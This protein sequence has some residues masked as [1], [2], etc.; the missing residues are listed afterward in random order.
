MNDMLIHVSVILEC[1]GN[2]KPHLRPLE[3]LLFRPAYI[4]RYLAS[5]CH[6]V[7]CVIVN[8]L[9]SAFGF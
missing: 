3:D 7:L 8:M 5:S 2:P 1:F 9:L 6:H 4:F